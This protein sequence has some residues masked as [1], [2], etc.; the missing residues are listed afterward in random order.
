MVHSIGNDCNDDIIR[1][2]FPAVHDMFD[3]RPKAVLEATAS[4]T[5]SSVDS[6]GIENRVAIRV[7]WVPFPAPG[8]PNRTSLIDVAPFSDPF[9][10]QAVCTSPVSS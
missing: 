10:A 4:R 1:Y 6:R 5:M 2:K 7:A 3:A 9:S 8:G